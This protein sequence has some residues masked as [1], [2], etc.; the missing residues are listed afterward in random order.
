MS[1]PISR[2]KRSQAAGA[3]VAAACLALTSACGTG[4]ATS[5]KGKIVEDAG[6]PQDGGILHTAATAD[7]PSLDI[8]KEASYMTHVAVG[9]V[10]SRLVAPKTGKDIEYGSS[11]LEGDLAEKWSKSED[12]KTWTFDL[13]QGVKFHDKPPVNGRELTSADV[14]CTVD[15]IKSLPGHQLGLVANVAKLE[16]PDPYT[17]IFNLISPNTAFDQ[18]MANPF[19]AILPCE[20][21]AGEFNLAEDAIGTG[22]FVLKSWKRDQERVMEKNPDYFIEG[23]PH[24]DGIQT[25]V[26]PDA[27]AQIAA[28]RSGKLDMISSLSTEKRQVDQ[29]LNQIDGLQLRTEKGITQTRVFM[30]AK[31]GPFS[32][33]GVRLAVA[34]AIDKEGMIKALRSGGT[35]TGPITPTLFGALPQDEVDELL[36]YDPEKAK[37]LLVEAGYP[38]GFSA[39]L[40]ATDGYGE[41]ILRE[42]QW[43]Q[44]DLAKI[45]IELTID[46]QDYATYVSSTW[47]ETK[48]DIMYGLQ[49]P[50]LTADEYLTSEYTSTGT[51][52]WSLVDDP[53]LDKMIAA[54]RVITDEAEREKALQDIERYIMENVSTPLPLYAYD[55]QTLYSG[56]V[57]DYHPHPDYSSRELQNVWM[58]QE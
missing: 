19:M 32:K 25:T 16:T 48:Y 15:R 7:A 58:E 42:A 53:E 33:L 21:T 2:L 4:A 57:H 6:P 54:Q 34:H 38:N 41:T 11:E 26:L 31:S 14:K 45:G 12:L 28:L 27:Q 8:Q 5:G 20:G 24:L 30:N 36:K 43:I 29:L 13:R 17:V 47:P 18:T 50:M 3:V 49:T 37:E 46:Q 39:E 52:N 22:P 9:T 56:K 1:H 44:E 55:T 23:L 10:Y 35:L 51:R 40:V